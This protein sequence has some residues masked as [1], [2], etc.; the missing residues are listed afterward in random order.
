MFF[1]CVMKRSDYQK[2]RQILLQEKKWPVNY[3]FKFIV[4]NYDG[5]VD[6]I[7][8][9]MPKNGKLSFKHTK[10]LNY[11]S[12]TCTAYMQNP[13]SIIQITQSALAVKGVIAL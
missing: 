10:S 3:M 13:E 11:V 12:V 6:A 8:A 5:K 4:P 7:I 2:F 1:P 9:L